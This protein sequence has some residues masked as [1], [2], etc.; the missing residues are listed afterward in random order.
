MYQIDPSNPETETVFLRYKEEQRTVRA[1]A[2]MLWQAAG[3]TI[4]SYA[5]F[6]DKLDEGGELAMVADY[7]TAVSAGLSEAEA[8]LLQKTSELKAL[9]EQMQASAPGNLFPGVVVPE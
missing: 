3:A 2:T 1:R 5:A 9:I 7:H 8:L 6:G 4:D